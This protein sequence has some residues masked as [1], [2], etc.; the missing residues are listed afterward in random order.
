M[1]FAATS[2]N[3]ASRD[4]TSQ[5]CTLSSSSVLPCRGSRSLSA[6]GLA[7]SNAQDETLFCNSLSTVR[8]VNTQGALLRKCVPTL[9]V[10]TEMYSA[11]RLTLNEAELGFVTQVHKGFELAL[12]L[13]TRATTLQP[14][15]DAETS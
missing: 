2:P 12:G 14:A 4:L 13:E 8:L 10:S 11:F 6:C 7:T 15:Q 9:P 1:D 3:V 5:V